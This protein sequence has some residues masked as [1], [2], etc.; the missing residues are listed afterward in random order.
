MREVA[1]VASSRT[2]LAKA[3][4]G[5]FNLTR[6]EDLVAHCIRELLFKVPALDP[7]EIDDVILG[8]AQPVGS[9]GLNIGRRAALLSGLPVSVCGVTIDRI[10]ASGLQAVASAAYQILGGGAEAIIAGGVESITLTPQDVDAH[11]LLLE[12]KPALY[13]ELGATAEILAQRYRIGREE[14]D[15]Y[16]LMSQQ[17]SARAEQ[18][19]FFR[20]EI[21]PIR[22][23][24]ALLDP[25]SD[26]HTGTEEVTCDRDEY[27]R[28]GLTLEDLLSL[29]P[30]F[31]S[32]GSGSITSANSAPLAD[33]ACVS[34]MLSRELADNLRIPYQLLFR[35]FVTA[36]CEPGEMSIGPVLAIPK[37]LRLHDLFIDDI[38]LWE[39]NESFAAQVIYCRD[40]LA[41]PMDKLN[42][43]GGAIALGHPY[44]MSGARLTAALA[45]E[46]SRRRAQFGVIA[47]A[48]GGGQGVAALF[49]SCQREPD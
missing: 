44:G 35:G 26:E 47:M 42:V 18:A 33:G 20:A 5:S 8:C 17:R 41:I 10:C 38:D 34:L 36:G 30:V 16:A 7:A 40:Q 1:I 48:V 45:N 39:I 29:R 24:R 14:Q 2:A 28:S 23:T 12:Q 4:S 32:S 43:N 6:P 21:V 11:P 37:L 22:V 25:N 13:M 3:F 31:D 27:P 49:E 9:Q 19:G 46:M 15:E